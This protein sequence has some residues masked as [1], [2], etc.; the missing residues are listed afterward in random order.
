MGLEKNSEPPEGKHDTAAGLVHAALEVKHHRG[1]K[2]LRGC[3]ITALL[4]IAAI[5]FLS[6]VQPDMEKGMA[7]ETVCAGAAALFLFFGGPAFGVLYGIEASSYLNWR[8][9]Q[10]P[11]TTWWRLFMGFW[12]LLFAALFLAFGLGFLADGIYGLF[13]EKETA[14]IVQMTFLGLVCGGVGWFLGWLALRRKSESTEVE[15]TAIAEAWQHAW[16]QLD[17]ATLEQQLGCPL[18][19]AYKAMLQPGS[20]WREKS[21][22][23]YPK[24]LDNEDDERY[25]VMMFQPPWPQAL[26]KHPT[27]GETVL[28]FA[29]A[30]FGVYFLKPGSEDPPVFLVSKDSGPDNIEEI[31]PHLSVFLGWPKEE[32]GRAVA[33][34]G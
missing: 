1:R 27:T 28:C 23:L 31:A 5:V 22:M 24:G 11:G 26:E 4:W 18:P 12:W 8:K 33:R 3:G 10:H 20:E 15:D 13:R 16:E 17:F 2:S 7:W 25:D 30:E 19:P 14:E 34:M 6:V 9:K 29:R 32:W 21:W